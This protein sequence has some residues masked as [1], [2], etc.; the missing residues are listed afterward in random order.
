MAPCLADVQLCIADAFI[1]H[2]HGFVSSQQY[3]AGITP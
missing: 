3:S 2:E 1:H